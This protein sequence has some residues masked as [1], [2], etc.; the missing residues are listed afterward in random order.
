MED[1]LPISMLNQLEYCERRFYLMYVRGEM[2]VNAHVLEG[3]LQHEQVHQ[4]GRERQGEILEYRRVYLWSEQ[5]KVAGFADVV[6][7]QVLNGE[8]VLIPIEYKKGRMGRW[9]N[10]HIQLCA[11]AL[12]LMERTQ[13]LVP[14][15]YVFYFGSRRREE[16]I[17]TPELQVRTQEAVRRAHALAAGPLPP[18]LEN[19][20]KCRDCSLEPICLPREVRR[21]KRSA[22]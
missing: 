12:C 2:E 6:E 18:P 16:V 20:R 14:K 22:P 8:R 3:A 1:Y 15:G 21:L 10:D 9:L 19:D 7:E 4:A 11:Q 17:F 13:A 5:L